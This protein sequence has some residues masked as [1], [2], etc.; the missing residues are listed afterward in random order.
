MRAL[1]MIVSFFT[2]SAAMAGG[3]EYTYGEKA[4]VIV[5]EEVKIS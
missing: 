3:V 1:L 5:N 4:V 2:A